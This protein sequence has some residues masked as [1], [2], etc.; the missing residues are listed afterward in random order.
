M[1]TS[2]NSLVSAL[3]SSIN[4]NKSN[5]GSYDT[6]ATIRRIEDGVAW[7]HIPGGVDETPVKLTMSAK[8]GDSVQVRVSNGS[9]FLVGNISSPPTDD[10][11]ANSAQKT[12]K[13][14]QVDA[15]RAREVADD[16][17][18]TADVASATANQAQYTADSASN[19]I[20]IL[21][22]DLETAINGG[23]S[24]SGETTI[25]ES[26]LDVVA[27]TFYD[28][29]E[30][31]LGE[32]EFVYDG[33]SWTLDSETVDL[34]DYGISLADS[35][36]VESGDTITINLLEV[37][38]VNNS[39]ENRFNELSETIDNVATEA[40]ENVTSISEDLHE[41]I[42]ENASAIS[43]AQESLDEIMPAA[44]KLGFSQEYGFVIFG[45]DATPTEKFKLQLTANAINF[46]DGALGND[47]AI[48]A[49]ITNS[50]LTINVANITSQLLF[51]NF[52]FIP[53]SNG[54][55]CLKYLGD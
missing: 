48:N 53:R 51:K 54:N 37:E 8:T 17:S 35:A 18:E 50:Q 3:Q 52:A 14:A 2:I 55:M 38:G 23:Y 11:I 49:Q 44:S 43:S 34:E 20:T 42:D 5:D 28:A 22:F 39:I 15:T 7:V 21:S 12:A 29:V 30:E 16:A 31:Q 46:V 26:G 33:T 27:K 13:I 36:T 10:T 25:A 9:A 1:T 41:Q 32:Y 4:S 45:Q 19:N 47:A 24:V 6:P 40:E